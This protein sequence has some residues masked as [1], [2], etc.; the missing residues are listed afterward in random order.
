LALVFVERD[1][2]SQVRTIFNRRPMVAD[3][4]QQLVVAELLLVG[5]GGVA[6]NLSMIGLVLEIDDATLNG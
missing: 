2:A 3:D 6:A 4:L 5:A 1:I